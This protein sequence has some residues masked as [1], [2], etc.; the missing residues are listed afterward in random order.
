MAKSQKQMV[1]KGSEEDSSAESV[2]DSGDEQT[3]KKGKHSQSA[4]QKE[5]GD[6]DESGDDEEEPRMDEEQLEDAQDVQ[7]PVI[8][9]ELM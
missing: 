7:T 6:I 2:Q 3:E 4:V 9:Q 1:Y 8:D 5:D